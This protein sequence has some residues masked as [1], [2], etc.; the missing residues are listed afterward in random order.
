[1]IV[2]KIREICKIQ[3]SLSY[4]RS[5]YRSRARNISEKVPGKT[6]EF[7]FPEQQMSC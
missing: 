1:M 6:E 7:Y 3:K 2:P 5:S 4:V